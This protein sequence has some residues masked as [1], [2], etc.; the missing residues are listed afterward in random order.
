MVIVK[1]KDPSE[2]SWNQGKLHFN[3]YF[4]FVGNV[5]IFKEIKMLQSNKETQNTDIPT[6]LIKNKVDILTEFVFTSFNKFIE[7]S[8]FPSKLK[9]VNI[10]TVYKK[11]KKLIPF[12]KL[13][14][15]I[16]RRNNFE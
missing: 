3:F 8:L 10:T 2:C 7:R 14:I 13:H 5:D 11:I 1:H 6:K 15:L 4:L 9:L 12:R 16:R